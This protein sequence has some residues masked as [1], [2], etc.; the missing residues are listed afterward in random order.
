MFN[1]EKFEKYYDI[2]NKYQELRIKKKNEEKFKYLPLIDKKMYLTYEYECKTE[3]EAKK[4]YLD[5]KID[6]VDIL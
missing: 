3:E 2:E 5:G 1:K 6:K 4:L